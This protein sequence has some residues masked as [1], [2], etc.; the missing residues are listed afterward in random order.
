MSNA[1]FSNR[2]KK[3]TKE[4]WSKDAA[5]F[6]AT[7]DFEWLWGAAVELHCSLYV[8]VEILNNALQ[9]GWTTV[10]WE[11]LK[12]DIAADQIN[13]ISEINESDAQGHYA[14]LCTSLVSVVGRRPYILLTVQLGSHIVTPG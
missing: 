3:T 12:K 4:R 9:F 6:D 13:R 5:L 10:L 2:T 11:N 8:S 14:V 7:A 1:C